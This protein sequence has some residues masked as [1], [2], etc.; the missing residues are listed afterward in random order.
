M[1]NLRPSFAAACLLAFLTVPVLAQSEA[2]TPR[3]TPA[4]TM[5]DVLVLDQHYSAGPG[6]YARV[7]LERGQV[8]RGEMSSPDVTLA[9]R[10]VGGRIRPPRVYSILGPESSSEASVV[11]IYPDADGVYEILAIGAHGGAFATHLQLYRDVRESHRRVALLR[12]PG[13]EIGFEIAGGWHSAFAQTNALPVAGSGPHAGSQV[14]ACFTAREEL[15]RFGMCAVGIGYQSQVGDRSILWF[16][17]EP[18]FLLIGNPARKASQWEA[19]ALF[20]FGAG[21][22]ERMSPTPLMYAPGAY[23]SRKIHSSDHGPS[24]TIQA[25]Y[26]HTWFS[27]FPEPAGSLGSQPQGDR[28]TLGLGWYQ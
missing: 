3:T 2:P 5:V 19:G 20:R 27:G 18:R 26:S 22:V 11:E 17:T 14:E 7:F 21:S 10:V 23:V 1:P 16:Y 24:W 4:D 25:S 9:I 28:I 12:K 6:E 15:G 13:W 8:Y